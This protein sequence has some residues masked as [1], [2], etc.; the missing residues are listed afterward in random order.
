MEEFQLNRS[1]TAREI[2]KFRA[3]KVNPL[4]MNRKN[5]VNVGPMKFVN[6]QSFNKSTDKS[7]S[8]NLIYSEDHRHKSS[9]IVRLKQNKHSFVSLYNKIYSQKAS[10]PLDVEE[11]D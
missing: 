7:A 8:K 5:S 11:D 9:Q 6:L 2:Y 4:A 10:K 3:K 1:C